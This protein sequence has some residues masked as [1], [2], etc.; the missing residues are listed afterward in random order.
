MNTED[1]KDILKRIDGEDYEG[2]Y[3]NCKTDLREEL[4]NSVCFNNEREFREIL[5]YLDEIKDCTQKKIMKSNNG[6]K[7]DMSEE[8]LKKMKKGLLEMDEKMLLAHLEKII[9]TSYYLGAFSGYVNSL[10]DICRQFIDKHFIPR[11]TNMDDLLFLMSNPDLLTFMCESRNQKIIGQGENIETSIAELK[12]RGLIKLDKNK[13]LYFTNRGN[14]LI[15]YSKKY[16]IIKDLMSAASSFDKVFDDMLFLSRL[17][18]ALTLM[19]KL[20][21]HVAP[22]SINLTMTDIAELSGRNLIELEKDKRAVLTT[23]GEK[24]LDCIRIYEDIEN[25]PIV[26]SLIESPHLHEIDADSTVGEIDELS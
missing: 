22:L 26:K 20:R 14:D 4:I 12:G 23:E 7:V 21:S 17:P 6:G 11:T 13:T 2:A 8:D 5:Q 16:P 9:S 3:R 25:P 15:E 18:K 10:C 1:K 19:L 24:L